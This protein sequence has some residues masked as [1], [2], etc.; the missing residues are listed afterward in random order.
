M[1]ETLSWVLAAVGGGLLGVLFFGGLWW[2]VRKAVRSSR[3]AGWL[4]GSGLVRT[5]VVLSGFYLLGRDD[6]R[7][8]V[9]GLIGFIVARLLVIRLTRPL[10]EKPSRGMKEANHA[11]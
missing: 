9:A 7:R 4:L 8:L 11:P 5:S 6:W 1:N 10:A 3:P 2:T